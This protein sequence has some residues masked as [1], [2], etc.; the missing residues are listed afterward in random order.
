M[1]IHACQENSE[2]MLAIVMTTMRQPIVKVLAKSSSLVLID[3][4]ACSS[5]SGEVAKHVIFKVL[6]CINTPAIAQGQAVAVARTLQVITPVK[7]TDLVSFTILAAF[8]ECKLVF[9]TATWSRLV[10]D[11][12]TFDAELVPDIWAD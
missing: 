5:V 4:G 11:I 7:V 10:F 1:A 6:T 3:V 8:T 2:I 12:A 9:D